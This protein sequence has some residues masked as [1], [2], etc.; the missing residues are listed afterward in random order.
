M[1]RLLFIILLGLLLPTTGL[2]QR[3]RLTESQREEQREFIRKDT[4]PVKVEALPSTINTHFS[5]YAGRLY[6]DSVFFFTSMRSDMR[7]DNDHFF[8]TSWYCNI[9]ETRLLRN[10]QYG[11]VTALPSLIN[12]RKFFN[13]N[14]CFNEQR[15]WL[16]FSRCNR[17][18]DG[19]L[20]CHLWETHRNKKGGRNRPNCHPPSMWKA[21]PPCNPV[22]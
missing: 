15:D 11:R 12:S 1:K 17:V 16:V 21:F 22:C 9:Y 6:P 20:R 8:E 18:G 4:L 7:E 2:A 19:E 10:G 3:V 14:F 5:E 13:S